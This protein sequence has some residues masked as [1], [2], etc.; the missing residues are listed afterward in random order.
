MKR[1]VFDDI[2][3]YIYYSKFDTN[4]ARRSLIFQYYTFDLNSNFYLTSPGHIF[5][6]KM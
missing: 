2:E 5:V 3:Q 6:R 1:Y 4:K